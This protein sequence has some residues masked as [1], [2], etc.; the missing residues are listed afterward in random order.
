[1]PTKIV[2]P[3]VKFESDVKLGKQPTLHHPI[4]DLVL[5]EADPY[6]SGD[7]GTTDAEEMRMGAYVQSMAHL[8]LYYIAGMTP[9]L[10]TCKV[11]ASAADVRDGVWF[12]AYRAASTAANTNTAYIYARE[13]MHMNKSLV[14]SGKKLSIDRN[15]SSGPWK[16]LKDRCTATES[17]LATTPVAS[18]SSAEIAAHTSNTV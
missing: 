8:G 6:K 3:L 13:L 17:K 7:T 9:E 5:T 16:I 2:S 11:T 4:H 18:L 1:M 12:P 15:T 10:V 14:V